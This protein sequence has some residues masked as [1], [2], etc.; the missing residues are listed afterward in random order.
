[1]V[2]NVSLRPDFGGVLIEEI[3]YFDEQHHY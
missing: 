2:L 3:T 1:M